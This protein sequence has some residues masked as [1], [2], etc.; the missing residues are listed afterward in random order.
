[1]TFS[2]ALSAQQELAPHQ[3]AT[4]DRVR[5]PQYGR[6]L[7]EFVPG[8][9]FVHPRGFSFERSGMLDFARTFMQTNPLYLNVEYAKA[10]GFSDL[11]ASPQM[12]FNVVLSL[13]VQNDSEKAIA[14]LGYYNAQFLRPVYPGETLRAYTKV[15]DRKERGEGKPGIASIRT[16]GVN[17]HDHVVLQYERKIMVGPRGD[18]PP[19]TPAPTEPVE[20][21]WV[22]NPQLE[23]PLIDTAFSRLTGPNTYFEDFQVGDIIVH[24]NGRTITDEH[25]ALTYS[26]C[27]THPLHFDRVFST[28]LSGKMSGEPIVYGG[29][30]FSWLEGLASRDVSENA[31]WEL[32]FT[33]GYHTQPA[34]SGDTVAALSRVLAIDPVPDNDQLGI[35]TFQF[36]GVKNISA[37]NALQTDGADLFIKENDK[38]KLGKEKIS[39][40]IFEIERRLL[41]KRRPS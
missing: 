18:R 4:L 3:S 22:E 1:M 36:I 27:N 20:F 6:Y 23:L 5:A 7:D 38:Q 2:L 35:V 15:M 37:A 13:G 29:L 33:E 26:V 41:I 40:K 14:N 30:V 34:V 19:T 9:V 16:L 28:G 39:H 17:Q 12:V 11:P 8:Q 31:L 24:P 10:H 25:M 32:G 21:P